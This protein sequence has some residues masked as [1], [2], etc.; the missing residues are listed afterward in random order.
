MKKESTLFLTMA[1]AA[2]TLLAIISSC[3]DESI[4]LVNPDV[5]LRDNQ[6]DLSGEEKAEKVLRRF[7]EGL[8][9]NSTTRSDITRFKVSDIRKKTTAVY[10]S[11]SPSTRSIGYSLPVYELTLQNDDNSTGFAVIAESPLESLVMAYAPVGAIS[12]TTYNKGLAVFFREFADYTEKMMEITNN[13]SAVTRADIWQNRWENFYYYKVSNSTEYVRDLNQYEID[14]NAPGFPNAIVDYST[15]IG[16]VIPAVWNQTSP[17]NNNVPYYLPGTNEHVRVGCFPVAL[18][19]I[20]SYYKTNNNYN[21]NILTATPSISNN[22]TS[23]VEVARLLRDISIE[24][25]TNYYPETN[26]GATI[27]DSMAPTIRKFGLNAK[28][29]NLGNAS[30]IDS[31][32]NNLIKNHPVLIIGDNSGSGGNR[33]AHIWVIDA[34]ITQKWWYYYAERIGSNQP[35][36][37]IHRVSRDRYE[38]KFNH[39]NWG[40]GGHS[41]GWY[42]SFTPTFTNDNIVSFV[43]NKILFTQIYPL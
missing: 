35:P 10:H 21:W 2:S 9:S 24:V 12:D 37:T 42:Y 22:T 18:G 14:N 39:C 25:K 29:T 20:M 17:Y 40:W 28:E 11:N 38:G 31:I 30:C 33:E 7:L 34:M 6:S 8:K 15:T 41:N 19:Q 32:A 4:A 16:T 1:L 27:V 3:S 5:S 36:Y 13:N 43:Y 23:S 26:Q